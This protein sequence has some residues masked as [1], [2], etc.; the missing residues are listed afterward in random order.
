MLHAAVFDAIGHGIDASA[1]TSLAISAYRNARR[2]G[3][4][5]VDTYRSIDKWVR[6]QH[7]GS[8]V[9]AVMAELDTGR[10]YCRKISAGHPGELLLRDGKLIKA[11]PAPTAMPLGFGDL[12]DPV[13][14][15]EEESLQPGDQLLLYT[16][17]V[18][19]ARTEDGDIFGLD[20]LVDFVTRTWLTSAPRRRRCVA[21]STRSWPTSMNTSRTTPPRYSSSGVLPRCRPRTWGCEPVGRRRIGPGRPGRRGHGWWPPRTSGV[22]RQGHRHGRRARGAVRAC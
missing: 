7:P 22:A 3:L 9:T 12:A 20:R 17:G 18:I 10:G 4:D 1:L 14:G 21:W 5:L 6:A 11:L 13:P 15:V 8:F 2:C 19:E 16:D